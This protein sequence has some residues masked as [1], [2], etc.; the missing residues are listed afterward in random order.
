VHEPE[1][2]DE[3]KRLCQEETAKSGK[4]HVV[5]LLHCAHLLNSDPADVRDK[6]LA[7]KCPQHHVRLDK[8][9]HVVNATQT[10]TEG[11]A[12]TIRFNAELAERLESESKRREMT[13][14][15]IVSEAL[16]AHFSATVPADVLRK[17]ETD[18]VTAR[19]ELAEVQTRE[20]A[21]RQALSAAKHE[22]QDGWRAARN[23]AEVIERERAGRLQWWQTE[24]ADTIMFRVGCLGIVVLAAVWW[25]GF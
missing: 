4:K 19:A 22:A 5:I 2:H 15:D 11:K 8:Y 12:M 13:Q 10:R 14:N 21:L 18:L 9:H 16:E 6:N 24:R 1:S 17:L 3:A 23:N 7:A 25:L 20:T